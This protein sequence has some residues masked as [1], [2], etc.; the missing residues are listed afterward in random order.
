MWRHVNKYFNFVFDL[1]CVA[2][3]CGRINPQIDNLYMFSVT[4]FL[5]TITWKALIA[6]AKLGKLS[7]YCVGNSVHSSLLILW[8]SKSLEM[9]HILW[10][11]K[12]LEVFPENSPFGRLGEML[13]PTSLVWCVHETLLRP[14]WDGEG[15]RGP[16]FPVIHS[17]IFSAPL[18]KSNTR[19]TLCRYTQCMAFSSKDEK[20][21]KVQ[22]WFPR[23][24]R[25]TQ[26]K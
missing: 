2:C 20:Y 7:E 9:R 10:K 6:T 25:S 19:A 22:P 24:S 12:A 14:F 3:M 23:G 18:Q 15:C 8:N 16:C 4:Q 17:H 5:G 1:I 13:C 11:A 26:M 21:F